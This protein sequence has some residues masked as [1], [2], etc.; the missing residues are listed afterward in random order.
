MRKSL[1]DFELLLSLYSSTFW[2]ELPC[3]QS[4]AYMVTISAIGR[5]VCISMVFFFSYN[6][7][8]VCLLERDLQMRGE[9]AF[10][11]EDSS[12]RNL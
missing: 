8:S 10:K 6:S 11:L 4:D 2:P 7:N 1:K 9:T 12:F 3:Q 5:Q